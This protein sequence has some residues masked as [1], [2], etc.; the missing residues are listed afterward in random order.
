M[1]HANWK[2]NTSMQQSVCQMISVL[3]SYSISYLSLS[4][5]F[6]LL[7]FL[8]SVPLFPP[9]FLFFSFSYV[10]VL[11]ALFP[12]FFFF[13]L[14]QFQSLFFPLEFYLFLFLPSLRFFL[15][16]SLSSLFS[17]QLA[18]LSSS[19]SLI[20]PLLFFLLLFS[21]SSK[22]FAFLLLLVF[23]NISKLTQFSVY[24]SV[25]CSLWAY[26]CS[27]WFFTVSVVDPV[28]PKT[29]G[30]PT[31]SWGENLLVGK[32][33]AENYMKMKE[34]GP[35]RGIPSAPL[36]TDHMYAWLKVNRMDYISTNM[37]IDWL[38]YCSPYFSFF[39]LL[40]FLRSQSLRSFRWCT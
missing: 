15:Y 20:F 2:V 3:N 12:V 33:F 13:F 7:P 22:L 24:T 35:G 29:G 23:Y 14:F 34:I 26:W 40:P 18:F 11:L 36:W 6:F 25:C 32:I 30:A 10:D 17:H 28:Y 19:C 37:W 27:L 21:S 8:F 5:H 31:L 1:T 39:L 38:L 16:F 9:P 4:F